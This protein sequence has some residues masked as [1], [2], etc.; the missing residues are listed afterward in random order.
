MA[1]EKVKE[2]IQ[3]CED[4]IQKWIPLDQKW[5]R[6]GSNSEVDPPPG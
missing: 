4:P 1:I 5:I 2:L 3:L 6:S